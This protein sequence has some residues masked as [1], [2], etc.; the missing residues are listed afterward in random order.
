M[1][2]RG[3]TRWRLFAAVM[4]VPA[5]LLGW[6]IVIVIRF[7][8]S[9]YP[10]G[11]APE[12]VPCAE[13]LRFGGA[14]VPEGAYDERCTVQTWLDTSYH[15]AFRMRRADVGTWLKDSYPAGPEPGTD[16]C[17]KGADLCLNM[18]SATAPPPPDAAADA[19]TVNVTYEGPQ[20]ALVRFSAFTV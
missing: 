17:E 14:R 11:G 5:L 20:G 6:V 18:D 12:T 9:D 10:L 8:T 16:L 15:A 7:M 13:A 4:A 19:V 3:R 1:V 2:V